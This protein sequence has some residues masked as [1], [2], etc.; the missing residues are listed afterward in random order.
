MSFE[1]SSEFV[2]SLARGLSVMRCFDGEHSELSQAD[3]AERTGLARAVVRRSLLTLQHLGYIGTR[4][5][6]F[7]LL[8][9]VLELGFG[10][11]SSL[12]LPQLALPAM[13]SLSQSLHESCSLAVLDDH[14]IVY[15]ARAA[16][17][18]VMSVTLNVGA[19]LPAF[20]TSMGR[21]L[22]AGLPDNQFDA[23]LSTAQLRQLTPHTIHEPNKLRAEVQKVRAN[24]YCL[25]TR[26]LEL[27]LCALA[28]P[29]RNRQQ[30][31][32]AALN[33]ALHY[34]S[35]IRS[36]ALEAVL[37]VLKAARVEIERAIEHLWSAPGG[38]RAP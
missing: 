2:Q 14:D 18:R 27:A 7:M 6:L 24:G 32:V 9:R 23:W 3:I 11:L 19:R 20:A 35:G 1:K 34:R 13:E 22:L 38:R 37:P 36:H 29:V 28:V 33:V 25:V 4:G 30:N 26:E 10:Y 5:R 15:V 17:R 8:P 12:R 16:A 21:V 31:T